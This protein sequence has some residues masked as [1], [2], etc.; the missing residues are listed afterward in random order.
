MEKKKLV[1]PGDYLMSCEEAVSGENTYTKNDEIYS[2]VF[3][4][5]DVA[6]GTVSVS[7]KGKMI[8]QPSVGMD[9]YCLVGRTSNTKA[10]CTCIS[11][12]EIEGR[13]RSFEMMA[14]LPVNAIRK[15]YV[16]DLRD[17]IKIGD[18]L[19]AKISKITKT[20]IDL[21]LMGPD[22]GVIYYSRGR[23]QRR[24]FNGSQNFGK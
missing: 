8:T 11:V 21:T 16:N 22:N 14:I 15:G 10:V 19:K 9:V 6:E 18:I 23:P 1:L 7:R 17:E 3:G 5:E 24:R 13:E 2:S 12:N 4:T 20:G